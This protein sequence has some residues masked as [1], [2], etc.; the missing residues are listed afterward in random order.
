M[1]ILSDQNKFLEAEVNELKEKVDEA[2]R[3]NESIKQELCCERKAHQETKSNWKVSQNRLEDD[4][5]ERS[6]EISK[7][8]ILMSNLLF[9]F[10]SCLNLLY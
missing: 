3:Q 6:L 8:S 5:N 4:Q 10:S 7:V 1:Q 2:E 9:Y